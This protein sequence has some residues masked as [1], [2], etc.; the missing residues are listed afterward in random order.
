MRTSPASVTPVNDTEPS[1]HARLR[2]AGLAFARVTWVVVVL[3]TMVLFALG[4][5]VGFGQL[6]TVCSDDVCPTQLSRQ[7]AELHQQLGLSL[8][9]Y[10]GYTTFLFAAFGLVFFAVAVLV[11]WRRSHDRMALLVSFF[12]VLL[13]G[14]TLP[15]MQAPGLIQ[16]QLGRLG[17]LML[18]IGLGMLPAIF[19]LFPDGRFV[20]RWMRWL[21]LAWLVRMALVAVNSTPP[22]GAALSGPPNP[23]IVVVLAAGIGAQV[24]RYQRV[25][26]PIQR[27]QTKWAVLG[28]AAFLASLLLIIL[29]NALVA[30]LAGPGLT[31]LIFERYVAPFLVCTVNITIPVTLAV[32]I[33]RYRLWDVDIVINR[34]MVYG[35]LT[36]VIVG[37]YVLVVGA[38]GAL[39][40]TRGSL[41]LAILATGLA[42][43]LFQPLRQRLQRAV[44]R[45]MYGERDD[46]YA[47]LAR[48]GQRV[49]GAL[50]PDAVLP[51]VA[52]TVREVLRLPYVAVYLQ[53]RPERF[54]R[55]AESVAPNVRFEDGKWQVPGLG[56]HGLCM[57]LV[58]QADTVGYIVLGPHAPGEAFTPAERKLLGDLAR[59]AGVAARAVRLTADLRRS[60]EQLVTAREEERRRLRRDLHDGLGTVLAA[61][62]L[63]TG[64]L[65]S[66]YRQDT[67]AGDA[68][69]AEIRAQL[70]GAVADIRR[71]V[72]DL[73]PPALD[74]LG[75]AGAIRGLAYR[76]EAAAMAEEVADVGGL[77]LQLQVSSPEALGPL[78][79]AIEVAAY[80]IAQEALANVV[81]H[82]RAQHCHI[83]V[84]IDGDL[85]LQISDDGVGLPD[86]PAAGVGL[87]SMAERAAEL[88]GTCRVEPMSSGGTRV[89]VRLP[90]PRAA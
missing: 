37:L 8:D 38:F 19:G 42:A 49:E 44:N 5:L 73:R 60:R 25:S 65:G 2:E 3:S 82:A 36:A 55:V 43:L 70:R 13:G 22:S 47:V 86:P 87:R 78:P 50:E 79:A 35:A 68:A 61:V 17:S 1:A 21:A 83:E 30:V 66:L 9:F 57:P 7:E 39:F 67:E 20:P 54:E 69:V 59:Q 52:A 77:R 48:L 64:A 12:L 90:L 85:R 71:L 41:L 88:G 28:F 72:Y 84:S 10:A 14:G 58:Y 51:T 80:R 33:L 74:E 75:L 81:K 89:A 56:S 26:T 23:I 62:N 34:A 32:S 29:A 31:R 27:Q 24:Y 53:H 15:V 45:L 6:R 63:Q 11:F 40:Q 76:A 46:P 18:L 16:P 4:L